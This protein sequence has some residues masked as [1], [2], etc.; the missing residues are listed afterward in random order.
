MP[1]P[2]STEPRDQQLLLRVT[3]RQMD[4]LEA[5]AHLEHTTPNSY[6]HQVLVEHLAKVVKNPR[7]QADLNNRAAYAAE[8]A[9]T[10][11]IR[12]RRSR[13][14]GRSAAGGAST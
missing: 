5:I 10:T 2:K 14:D 12:G 13:K 7:V 6:A 9:T 1:R 11:P 4:V 3:T 8:T